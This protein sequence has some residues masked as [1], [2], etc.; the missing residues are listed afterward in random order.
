MKKNNN[1]IQFIDR[2]RQF[3]NEMKNLIDSSKPIIITIG[4]K[5]YFVTN[6]TPN[7]VTVRHIKDG[8]VF[9]DVSIEE[10]ATVIPDI[11]SVTIVDNENNE[12][13]LFARLSD[14][15]E[16][17]SFSELFQE[18]ELIF[19]SIIDAQSSNYGYCCYKNGVPYCYSQGGLINNLA[20][21]YDLDGCALRYPG[22]KSKIYRKMTGPFWYYVQEYGFE[23]LHFCIKASPDSDLKVSHRM[24]GYNEQDA[25]SI[26]MVDFTKNKVNIAG[27]VQVVEEAGKKNVRIGTIGL[28]LD[29]QKGLDMAIDAA[30]ASNFAL[31]FEEEEKLKEIYNQSIANSITLFGDVFKELGISYPLS[32]EG[33]VPNIEFEIFWKKIK[34]QPS[35]AKVLEANAKNFNILSQSTTSDD[36]LIADEAINDQKRIS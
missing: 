27:D 34:T 12:K 3:T 14:V 1:E 19:T 13:K 16:D 15:E 29:Y 21:P 23:Y 32:I 26:L 9:S 31:T 4:D 24:T 35:V 8:N 22:P 36:L 10:L 25:V 18:E 20:T 17:F 28:D 2:A 33:G 7:K 30:T 6:V 5:S 11:E